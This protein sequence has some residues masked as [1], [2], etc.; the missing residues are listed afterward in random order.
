MLALLC[1]GGVGTR[2]RS[3]LLPG[4]IDWL[5]CLKKC[6]AEVTGVIVL[7]RTSKLCGSW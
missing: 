7:W 3:L 2:V 4:W 6:S 5:F 1:G